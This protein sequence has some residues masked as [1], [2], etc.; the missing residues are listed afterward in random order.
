MTRYRRT[1]GP[2]RLVR[3]ERQPG[4]RSGGFGP[5]PHP[6]C[7]TDHQAFR[8]TGGRARDRLR[9]PGRLDRQPDRPQRRRQ[10]DVLQRDRRAVRPH[11]RVHRFHGPADDL[12]TRAR[13][14][15]TAVL[16]RP[17]G[18]GADPVADR[19]WARAQHRRPGPAAGHVRASRR[20]T[21][22]RRDP[23]ALVHRPVAPGGHL[24]QRP[25][26]RDRHPGHRPD[27]PEHPPV[28]E[29]D[30]TRERAR[31]HA[32]PDARHAARCRPA[33]AWPYDRGA[34]IQRAGARV[35]ALRRT[36]RAATTSLPATSRTATSAGWRSPGHWPAGRSCC[37]S[38]SRPRA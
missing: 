5:H 25:T 28:P 31:R 11:V 12:A 29:H 15:R 14:G 3:Y 6:A 30:G 35:A 38:T 24:P 26:P 7:P 34:G 16:V 8:W 32:L 22:Y 10:D 4:T 2:G 21:A 1:P 13:L 9:D 27:L 37:C 17:A 18:A 36:R 23:A 20:L 33:P 19:V